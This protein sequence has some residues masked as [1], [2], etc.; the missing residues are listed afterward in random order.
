MKYKIVLL[1]LVFL[2]SAAGRSLGA[3]QVEDSDTSDVSSSQPFNFNE[4]EAV[5]YS[6][7][8]NDYH[9]PRRHWCAVHEVG[10]GMVTVGGTTA[11]L[12]AVLISTA[13]TADTQGI[14]PKGQA[15]SGLGMEVLG[16]LTTVAGAPLLIGGSIHDQKKWRYGFVGPK[17]GVGVAYN[18]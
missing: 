18:F 10:L 4:P 14:F 1:S 9:K 8:D 5:R 17:G 11:L 7:A 13:P 12:G 3:L 16:L 15:L 6:A 2:I